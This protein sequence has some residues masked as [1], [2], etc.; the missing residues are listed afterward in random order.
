MARNPTMSPASVAAHRSKTPSVRPPAHGRNRPARHR[1]AGATAVR[2][3]RRRPGRRS[4]SP[5]ECERATARTA[6]KPNACII[7]SEFGYRANQTWITF[8]ASSAAPAA[9]AV[10][11]NS[12]RPAK[13]HRQHS[14]QRQQRCRPS[15]ATQSIDAVA[16]REGG[17]EEMR[18]LSD[19]EAASGI[20]EEEAH[21]A[22]AVVV[23]ARLSVQRVAREKEVTRIRR[24]ERDNRVVN[25]VAA[26]SARSGRLR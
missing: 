19:D 20:L 3:G 2:R 26:T 7:T 18:E 17:G 10:C 15:H 6:A 1:N 13:V 11:P 23:G 8:N 24:H 22:V 21:E 16:D 12:C 5:S 25:D 4:V 14:Q 9:A